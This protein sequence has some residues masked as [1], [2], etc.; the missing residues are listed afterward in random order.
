MENK[1]DVRS[2]LK[3]AMILFAITLISGLVLGLVYELTKEPIRLQ[4][5]KAIQEA[6]KAVFEQADSFRELEYTVDEELSA[7]L[8]A[9][10]VT[11]GKA[12]EALDSAG[13]PLGYVIQSTSSEG[14]GG[15]I[16]IYMGVTFKKEL[17]GISILEIAETPGLGMKADEELTPQFRN[18]KVQE[19]T[20]TKSGSKSDSE[21]DAISGA[22]KTTK[23][24]TDAVNGGMKVILNSLMTIEEAKG[25]AVN[26]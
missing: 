19:F 7:E 25:G 4:Q 8:S 18:K 16:T 9:D 12:Y 5:E 3:D 15:D 23:A 13:I 2:M 6:C 11:V 26:E 10:G 20:Y 17:N 14:Y 22:T 1:A 21:I 24:L